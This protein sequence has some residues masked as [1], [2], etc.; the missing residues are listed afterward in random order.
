ML[1]PHIEA[2]SS[3][4]IFYMKKNSSLSVF[5][6]NKEEKFCCIENFSNG[7]LIVE[8]KH[9]S[10]FIVNTFEIELER[11]L[12]NLFFSLKNKKRKIEKSEI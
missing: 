10:S 2:K 9:F 1:P 11:R 12:Q 3:S 5:Y 4:A 6:F 8:K 7:K